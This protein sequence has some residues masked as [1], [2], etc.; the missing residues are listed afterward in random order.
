MS[1]VII[2]KIKQEIAGLD[3]SATPQEVGVVTG[4]GDGIAEIDGLKEA[5][6][7]EMV[8]FADAIIFKL[9]LN[10]YIEIHII[11]Y[12]SYLLFGNL[13]KKYFIRFRNKEL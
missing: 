9:N 7:M 6:M 3:T 2:D 13:D 12:C 5:Q 10:L 1:T 8:V 4:V 11:S